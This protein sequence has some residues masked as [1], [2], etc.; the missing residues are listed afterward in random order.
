MMQEMMTKNT[1][2]MHYLFDF[3]LSWKAKGLMA[4]LM[5]CDGQDITLR[6]L[7]KAA[8]DGRESTRRAFKE[9][10]LAGYV[11]EDGVTMEEAVTQL[12]HPG[13]SYIISDTKTDQPNP[14]RA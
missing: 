6:G 12:F 2:T 10:V 11:K 14:R 8:K 1:R 7:S 5:D 3:S 13:A 4:Y 9:L